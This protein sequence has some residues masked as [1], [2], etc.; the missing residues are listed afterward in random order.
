MDDNDIIIDDLDAIKAHAVSH[1]QDMLGGISVPTISSQ[2][3]IAALVPIKCDSFSISLLEAPFSAQEIKLAFM[4]LPKNKAPWPDGYPGEFFTAHWDIVGADMI[5]AVGEFLQ[6][7]QLL[8]QWNSTILTLVP[9]KTNACKISDFR[10]ISC[11]NSVYKVASKLLANRLKQVL[12]RLISNVQSA[13]IPGR[14]LVENVL[15]A[16]ELVKG[17]NWKAISK[18]CMLKV[19]LRKA[20]DTLNWSFILNTLEAMDFPPMFRQLIEQCITT[21]RFSVAINGEL[22][23]YFRGTKGLRQGDPL[24][25]YLFV[26]ALEVFSQMLRGKFSDG[27]IGYHPKASS[28]SVTHLAFADESNCKDFRFFRKLVWTNNEQSIDGTIHGRSEP[29]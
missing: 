8:Q 19:D 24:S 7:G 5:R 2:Q 16:T 14:L 11:C 6:T 26:L 27:S 3:D 21:T 15:L 20:F 10:P 17:Y 12:P 1:Y 28:P 18:R 22:C 23:G 4:S 25:P 29:E 13:F 9:K